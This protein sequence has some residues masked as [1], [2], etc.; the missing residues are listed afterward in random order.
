[1]QTE[2]SQ[3]AIEMSPPF[4]ATFYLEPEV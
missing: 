1:V 2:A 3:S 4:S